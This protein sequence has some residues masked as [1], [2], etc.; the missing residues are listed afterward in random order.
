MPDSL[1]YQIR[2]VHPPKKAVPVAWAGLPPPAGPV[3]FHLAVVSALFDSRV[4]WPLAEHLG[5]KLQLPAPRTWKP[6]G[7]IPSELGWGM[8]DLALPSLPIPS[9]RATDDAS[10]ET[11][12]G[13]TPSQ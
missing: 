11:A 10:G 12:C 3:F 8:L 13:S 7:L 5:D 9:V 1:P 4:I 6:K 2:S